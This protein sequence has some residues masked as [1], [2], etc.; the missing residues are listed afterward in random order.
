LSKV[1]GDSVV[2]RE[3]RTRKLSISLAYQNED[4]RNSNHHMLIP[5][6][7]SNYFLVDDDLFVNGVDWESR[8]RAS[9]ISAFISVDA[10]EALEKLRSRQEMLFRFGRLFRRPNLPEYRPDSEDLMKF[11]AEM[12]EVN[13]PGFN[14]HL[15]AG[16]TFLGQFIDHDISFDNTKLIA[17]GLLAAED[18]KN[19]RS[20]SFDLDSLYGYNPD[21]VR[22][23]PIGQMMY[24]PDGI[25]LRVGPTLGDPVIPD[26]KAQESFLNDL[27]RGFDALRPKAAAIGDPRNDENLATAQTHLAF[28]KFHNAVVDFL[29][30]QGV[31]KEKLFTAARALVTRHY[32][33][34]VLFDY[35]DKIIER[36]V[37]NDVIK[38]GCKH[39]IIGSKEQSF[40]P[41]EF[42]VA[43]FRLGHS[44][45]TESYEWNR[46]FQSHGP[47]PQPARLRHL[48]EFTGMSEEGMLGQKQLLSSW[49]IDW[50]RFFNF[51]NSAGMRGSSH[52]N[53]ARK[54]DPSLT[55]GMMD[56]PAIVFGKENMSNALAVQNLLR[57]RLLGVPTGQ[58]IAERLNV[59]ALT[60][61]DFQ[62]ET[63]YPMLKK[64]G[65]DRLTPLW[66]YILKEAKHFHRGDRLGPVGSRIVAET[67]VGLIRNSR[68]SIL[69]ANKPMW[70]PREL[71]PADGTF[72][73]PDLL[74][75]V[76][77][78]GG[79]ENFLNPLGDDTS[80]VMTTKA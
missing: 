29:K 60:P 46:I 52:G 75:F 44:Q 77:R 26:P 8:L 37:I 48:F 4:R 22:R 19:R 20:P 38:N 61:K 39:L 1:I 63:A 70:K 56:L 12:R 33:H 14:E 27:P 68:I 54:L 10:G 66:Y 47:E 62:D 73:M 34:I 3:W 58:S 18:A 5:K 55:P 15:P 74:H 2:R 17:N 32:Q 21:S 71:P 59:T 72:S 43:A 31:P 41:I 35:L 11:G 16:Y 28:I 23:S 67:A 76:H 25:K 45:V 40:M 51:S 69:P 24:D 53:K 13:A 50:T 64:L 57:S 78:Y 65:Y 80:Q 49:I 9:N 42:S 6:E 79:G 36:G 30:Q 7:E